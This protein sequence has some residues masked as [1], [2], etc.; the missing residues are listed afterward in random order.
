[1]RAG[2]LSLAANVSDRGNGKVRGYGGMRV[3]ARRRFILYWLP[4]LAWAAV[5][6][7]STSLPR[8]PVPAVEGG[9]KLAHLGAYGI[10]GLLL[11][12]ALSCTA[13]LSSLRGAA[14]TVAW[15]AAFG[16]FDELHQI[17]LPGRGADVRDWLADLVGLTLGAALAWVI[18]RTPTRRRESAYHEVACRERV[19]MAEAL[20]LT[21]DDFDR[22]ILQS[23]QPAMVDFW[24]PWCGP[25]QM[26]GP[27]IDKL[28]AAYAGRAKIAKVNVDDSPDLAMKYGIRSIPSLLFF[29][30]GQV[31]EQ[32]VGVQPEAVLAEKLDS[33][34]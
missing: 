26:M 27:T 13:D 3:T 11:M 21:E 1:M 8:V 31:V 14:A 12:R 33:L 24:A 7:V 9:D 28:A 29:K 5:I 6:L 30:D 2:R 22:E 32:L 10:L 20:H 16:A 17:P 23:D 19:T 18:Y 25:C 15:G 34:L 4:A